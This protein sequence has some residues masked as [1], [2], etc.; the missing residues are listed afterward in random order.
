MIV[1]KLVKVSQKTVQMKTSHLGQFTFRFATI[2]PNRSLNEST[3]SVASWGSSTAIPVTG[4]AVELPQDATDEVDSFKLLF[5][6]DI[7]DYIVAETKLYMQQKRSEKET[8]RAMQEGRKKDRWW[9]SERDGARIVQ[10]SLLSSLSQRTLITMEH[11]FWIILYIVKILLRLKWY[12]FLMY[13][14]LSYQYSYCHGCKFKRL[15]S[16]PNS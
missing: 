4:I 6:D 14:H 1:L 11:F 8:L 2:S 12:V 5:C 3:S 10:I 7:V 9:S 16:E 13:S 15:I